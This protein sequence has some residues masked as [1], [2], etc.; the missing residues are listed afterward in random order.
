MINVIKKEAFGQKRI[1]KV[2]VSDAKEWLIKMQQMDGAWLQFHT[3]YS[4]RCKTGFS[5]GGG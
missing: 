2:K 5:D 4:R 1:D 3:Y